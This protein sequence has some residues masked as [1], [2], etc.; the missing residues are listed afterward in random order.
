MKM[1]KRCMCTVCLQV[2]VLQC[3]GRQRWSVLRHRL[4]KYVASFSVT[5]YYPAKDRGCWKSVTRNHYEENIALATKRKIISAL[6]FLKLRYKCVHDISENLRKF[7]IEE[8]Y[9]SW[10][11]MECKR[12]CYRVTTQTYYEI[13]KR[14][15]MTQYQ[16]LWS[17]GEP[18]FT[19]REIKWKRKH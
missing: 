6:I 8:N 14:V 16:S 10:N 11:H 2:H 17:R 1:L 7:N 19:K 5:T 18:K 9:P 15:M 12:G 3:T 4:R 13:F